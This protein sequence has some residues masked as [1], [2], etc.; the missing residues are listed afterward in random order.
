MLNWRDEYV[1]QKVA[2][3]PSGTYRVSDA[4]SSGQREVTFTNQNGGHFIAIC[5]WADDGIE[6]A[7]RHAAWVSSF[8]SEEAQGD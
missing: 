2:D 5:V 3:T 1:D 4:D 7:E 6:A 8:N